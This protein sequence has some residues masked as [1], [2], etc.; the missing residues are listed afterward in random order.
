MICNHIPVF[1]VL[2]KTLAALCYYFNTYGSHHLDGGKPIVSTLVDILSGPAVLAV[3]EFLRAPFASTLFA[4]SLVAAFHRHWTLAALFIAVLLGGIASGLHTYRFIYFLPYLIAMAALFVAESKRRYPIRF[5]LY[6]ATI[7]GMTTS[8]A[9][10]GVAA[11]FH[12][13][14]RDM[15]AFSGE[16]E[17][18]VGKGPLKVYTG[19]YETYYV[20]REL[21]WTQL[22]YADPGTY[23]EDG[24]RANLI[25]Q[26]D[27]ALE[28]H[29][30]PFTAVE[31]TYTLLGALREI[32]L[33]TAQKEASQT[34]K[35]LLAKIGTTFSS[36]VPDEE[37]YA[38]IRAACAHRGLKKTAEV[39]VSSDYV[40]L[41]VYRKNL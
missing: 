40:P 31:E 30:P 26:A 18:T 27:A 1:P 10:Y 20:G 41:I 4:I 28:P 37:S 3:K 12:S 38:D 21:G 11:L 32:T 8:F 23:A 7:Y 2:T 24:K 17:R 13:K 6:A 39:N 16:L 9:A 29:P 36:H 22:A 19:S 34:N 15:A 25:G 33:N 14:A 35:S 5:L